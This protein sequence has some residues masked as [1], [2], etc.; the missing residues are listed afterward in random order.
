MTDRALNIHRWI[1]DFHNN[2]AEQLEQ[3]HPLAKGACEE[4]FAA[5]HVAAQAH[6]SAELARLVQRTRDKIADELMWEEDKLLS[7]ADP[8]YVPRC[9]RG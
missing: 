9:C 3:I 2:V 6:D 4:Y 8:S 7:A 1:E 5:M